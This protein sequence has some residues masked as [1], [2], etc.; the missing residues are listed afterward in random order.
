MSL[1]QHLLL[2]GLVAKFWKQPYTNGLVRWGTDIHDPLMLP[3]FARRISA[4]SSHLREAG[5]PFEADWFAPH[6]EFRFPRI[7]EWSNATFTLNPHR[8]R[9][10]ARPG[11]R[12]RR[13]RARC[14]Y[15]D[16]SLERLQV[17]S[18]RA[19]RRTASP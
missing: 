18:A 4:M 12:T 16:S 13:R 2:R 9:T 1:A 11:R 15:V 7:G 5:F 3:H 8:A 14:R 10:V 19:R 6:F 17:K